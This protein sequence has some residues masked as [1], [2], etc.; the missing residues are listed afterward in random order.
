MDKYFVMSPQAGDLF[1]TKDRPLSG[2]DF[3]ISLGGDTF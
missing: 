2:L 3:V 1:T